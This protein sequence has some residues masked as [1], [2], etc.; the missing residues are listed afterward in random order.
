MEKKPKYFYYIMT[1][2]ALS[3]WYVMFLPYERNTLQVVTGFSWKYW[4]GDASQ[5]TKPTKRYGYFLH[6]TDMHID[7][8]YLPGASIDSDCHRKPSSYSLKSSSLEQKNIPL[9]GTLGSPGQ[10]CDSPMALIEQTLNWVKKEWKHKLD[11]VIWTGDN[12]RHDWDKEKIRKRKHIYELNQRVKEL[13]TDTFAPTEEDDRIIPLVPAIGNNDIHPHNQIGDDH[14]L[15]SF[16]S[17]LWHDWI[18]QDQQKAFQQ[19]GYYAVDV[20]KG[21]RVLSLNTLYFYRKNKQVHGCHKHG[22]SKQHMD[23]V[24]EQLIK[25]RKESNTQIYI[26][27]HI[28][29]SPRDYR[30]TCFNEYTRLSAEYSDI[31]KGQFFGHLNMDHFLLYNNNDGFTTTSKYMK[32]VPKYTSQELSLYGDQDINND[33]DDKDVICINR[34]VKKYVNWLYD[35]YTT[36][37]APE[38]DDKEPFGGDGDNNDDPDFNQ[39]IVIQVAP[40]VLPVYLPSLRIYRYEINDDQVIGDNKKGN[41]ETEKVSSSSSSLPFGTLIGYDQ[42][43]ANITEWDQVNAF[44]NTPL[45]YK[46]EYTTEEAYG[47]TDLSPR[48][49][50]NLAKELVD[51]DNKSDHLWSNFIRNMF[52]QTRDNSEFDSN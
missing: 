13:M 30:H 44:K 41:M 28:P 23:W 20:S 1:L 8:S 26:M 2:L 48:S 51:G 34:N 35:M 9:A 21:L 24:E 39:L 10:H 50:F 4:F 37:D 42:Y 40:S 5:S 14:G 36:V 33:D 17:Q 32:Y 6:I 49:Y 25:A 12:A 46:L 11:F 27:G 47:L 31:I 7:E 38:N 3:L 45:E 43:Y 29:P 52:V 15:L 19:G 18:P 22:L 16:Y